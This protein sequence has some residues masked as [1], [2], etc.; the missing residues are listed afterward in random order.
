MA[1]FREKQ[2]ERK[3]VWLLFALVRLP[4]V[5]FYFMREKRGKNR[6][7]QGAHKKM[8][9]CSLWLESAGD[10]KGVKDIVALLE[11]LKK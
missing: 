2:K 6:S 8:T 1:H 10:Q 9:L 4:L 3:A 11:L 7:Q 5:S